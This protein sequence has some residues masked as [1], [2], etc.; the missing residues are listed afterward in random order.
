MSLGYVRNGALVM[1]AFRAHFVEEVVDYMEKINIKGFSILAG[2]T[3]ETQPLDVVINKPFKGYM[4]EEWQKFMSEPTVPSDFTKS[5][6]RKRPSYERILSMVNR[7]IDRLNS[8]PE[9]FE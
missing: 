5:G 1:D 3:S 2:H 8:Y 7:S 9:I 6:N 4:V